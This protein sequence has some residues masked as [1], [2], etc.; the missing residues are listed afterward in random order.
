MPFSVFKY[1]MEMS[2]LNLDAFVLLRFFFR[3]LEREENRSVG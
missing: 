3:E 2:F 1:N